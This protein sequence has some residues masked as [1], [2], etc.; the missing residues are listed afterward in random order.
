MN[1]LLPN[2]WTL[3]VYRIP[4][5]PTRLR[6]SVWRKLQA[7]GA[8]YLQD[9]VCLLPDRSDL[10][11]NLTFIADSITEM[12]GTSHLF[13]AS[14]ALPGGAERLAD[15]FRNAAD[16]RLAE[17]VRN[18]DTVSDVLDG[19][20]TPADWEQAEEALKRERV[21]YLHARRRAYFGSTHG[22]QVDELLDRLRRRLDDLYRTGGGK[23]AC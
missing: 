17:V 19:A 2:R 12:E 22:A 16:A 3:L 10:T 23:G 18:L 13:S 21:A 1:D 9:G 7:M 5:Q 4:P 14:T 6:I 8:L 11:E 15:A 20:V